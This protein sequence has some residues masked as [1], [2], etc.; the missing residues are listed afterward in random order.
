MRKY[1]DIRPC[2]TV[3]NQ[4]LTQND[5]PKTPVGYIPL[6]QA[7]AHEFDTL[8]TV[9]QRCMFITEQ[10]GQQFAVMTVDQALCCYYCLQQQTYTQTRRPAYIDKFF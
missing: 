6:I 4:S 1:C 2:W 7:P 3:F 5:P 10:L 9:I 8:K